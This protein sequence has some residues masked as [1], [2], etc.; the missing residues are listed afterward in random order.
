[1]NLY[2]IFSADIVDGHYCGNTIL[3]G[4]YIPNFHYGE[5]IGETI[6]RLF[7]IGGKYIKCFDALESYD[8]KRH[9][10]FEVKD[11][12]G[13]IPSPVGIKFGHKFILFSLLCQINFVIKCICDYI[14]GDETTKLRIAY[15]QYYYFASMILDVN[16]NVYANFTMNKDLISNEFRNAMAHY[17]IGV[18]LKESE[19]RFDDPFY[20]VVQKYFNC[21][22]IT[23]KKLVIA[24]LQS[25]SN[26][27]E[28]YLE[29]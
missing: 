29:L 21:D 11:F 23:L 3:C 13:F 8:V 25:V 4:C 16:K 5:D 10:K 14:I 15:L 1:M 6:K 26:Q 9:M 17:K 7:E 2:D 20:G 27:I 28:T 18:T 12:G 19:I 22:T 24:E